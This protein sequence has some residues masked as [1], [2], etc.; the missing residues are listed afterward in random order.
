MHSAPPRS[1][2]AVKTRSAEEILANAPSRQGHF[3][4]VPPVI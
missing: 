4:A 1:D 3:F 2:Q